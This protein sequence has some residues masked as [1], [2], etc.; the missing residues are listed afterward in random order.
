MEEDMQTS[1]LTVANKEMCEYKYMY[2][3]T[4]VVWFYVQCCREREQIFLLF[5]ILAHNLSAVVYVL[6]LIGHLLRVSNYVFWSVGGATTSFQL[7][8][9]ALFSG[10][11][12][13]KTLGIVSHHRF[14]LRVPTY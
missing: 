11:V 2:N 14:E 13:Q 7:G 4:Y 9:V 10:T 8:G 1:D 3:V 6:E 12:L 5:Y